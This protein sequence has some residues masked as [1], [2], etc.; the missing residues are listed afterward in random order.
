MG[1]TQ[2][3]LSGVAPLKY[4]RFNKYLADRWT[5]D[6]WRGT[7]AE[8]TWG[9]G[10]IQRGSIPWVEGLRLRGIIGMAGTVA[11]CLKVRAAEKPRIGDPVR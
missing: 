6:G 2:L 7:S 3:G 8:V 11:H 1:C 4:P 10:G 5:T 9:W